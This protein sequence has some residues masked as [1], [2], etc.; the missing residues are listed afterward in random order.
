MICKTVKYKDFFGNDRKDELYFHLSKHELIDLHFDIG[1]QEGDYQTAINNLIAS[2]NRQEMIGILTGIMMASYGERSEDGRS[3]LKEDIDGHKLANKFKQMA[4]FDILYTELLSSEDVLM[5]F[6]IGIMPED[7]QAEAR[8]EASK[9][10]A[11][12]TRVK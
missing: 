2:D 10:T 7:L 5:E 9:L 1:G 12:L 3:F 11:E 4:A 6:I 8:G